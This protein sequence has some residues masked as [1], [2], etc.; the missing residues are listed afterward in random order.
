LGPRIS[1]PALARPSRE[2]FYR[3]AGND[4]IERQLA[5]QELS[6][7]RATYSISAFT[8]TG[9]FGSGHRRDAADGRLGDMAMYEQ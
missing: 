5:G 3:L 2:I 6:F 4:V 9:R 8:V 7:R 1:A